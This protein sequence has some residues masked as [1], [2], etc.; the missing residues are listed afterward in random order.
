VA[1]KLSLDPGEKFAINGAVIVNGD[2]HAVLTVDNQA[3]VLRDSDVIREDEARTPATRLY[4]VCMLS[5]LDADAA[6]SHYP[7]FSEHMDAFMDVV[8]NPRVRLICAQV[9]LAMMNREYYRALTGCRELIAY[10]TLILGDIDAE[11]RLQSRA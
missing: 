3:G 1:F 11:Q 8:E 6:D 4:F 7:R 10:E 9:S 5:Y 2:R